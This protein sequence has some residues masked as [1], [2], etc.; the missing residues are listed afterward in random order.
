MTWDNDS[1]YLDVLQNIEFSLKCV[2]ESHGELTDLGTVL[3][4]N[5]GRAAIKQVC[6]YGRGLNS[7]P[8]NE[9][10]EMIINSIVEIGK[11]RI[12][13]INDLTLTMFEKCIGQVSRSVE[14]HSKQGI[15]G[16]YEFIKHYVK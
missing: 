3:A 11:E 16:Y 1:R 13:K 12:G 5:K 10:E 6:G 2:Y 15:R 9:M 4:L 7:T 14:R 8:N